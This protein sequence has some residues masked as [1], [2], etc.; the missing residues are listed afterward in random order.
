MCDVVDIL[1]GRELNT[2]KELQEYL[3]EENIKWRKGYTPTCNTNLCLCS[4]D[5]E[6]TFKRVGKRLVGTVWGYEEKI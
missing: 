6:N 1:D 3:G 4:V 5:I 2:I